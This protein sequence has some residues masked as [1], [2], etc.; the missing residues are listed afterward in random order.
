[1]YNIVYI[2][3]L[4]NVHCKC[5]EFQHRNIIVLAEMFGRYSRAAHMLKTSAGASL[6]EL[7]FVSNA[8]IICYITCSESHAT[9]INNCHHNIK[10]K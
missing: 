1:M 6:I 10:L 8:Y 5:F 9:V 4:Y 7:S 3:I 2:C